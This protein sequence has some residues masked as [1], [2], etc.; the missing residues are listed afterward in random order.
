MIRSVVYV[1]KRIYA[2]N[3]SIIKMAS[4]H[5]QYR[6]H[7]KSPSWDDF[8]ISEYNRKRDYRIGRRSVEH[9]HQ[10]LEWDSYESEN[11]DDNVESKHEKL[12]KETQR[13]AAKPSKDER[14]E[15]R[16]CKDKS[17]KELSDPG[18]RPAKQAWAEV[19]LEDSNVCKER[20]NKEMTTQTIN[21]KQSKHRKSKGNKKAKS[22]TEG[23]GRKW[24]NEGERLNDRVPPFVSY[25]WA[26]DAPIEKKYTHNVRADPKDVSRRGGG[27]GGKEGGK[28][29]L[30]PLN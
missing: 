14:T 24:V 15:R 3:V 26:N 9:R 1:S 21:R 22:K 7:F 2:T 17:S 4:V 25:G 8:A 12:E 5:S 6:R 23:D 16:V 20:F 29:S 18:K 10:P 30:S 13:H 19:E 28:R 27:G 11:S